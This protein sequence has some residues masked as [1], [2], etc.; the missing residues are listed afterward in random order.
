M[1]Q[2]FNLRFNEFKENDPTSPGEQMPDQYPA[3]SY[4]RNLGFAW[5]DGRMLFLNYSYLVSCEHLA[6][7]TEITLAFTTHTVTIKGS[8]LKN[9]F[10]ELMAHLPKF[11][12]GTEARY[13]ATKEKDAPIINEIIVQEK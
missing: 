12:V 2:D 6:A 1:S 7:G 10:N 9:L 8:N 4:T 5:P 11:I 13:N 3:S